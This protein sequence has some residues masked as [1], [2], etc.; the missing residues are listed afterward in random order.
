MDG[1]IFGEKRAY[2]NETDFQEDVVGI[3]HALLLAGIF[4]NRL[5]QGRLVG[6]AG[7]E[8]APGGI[9]LPQPVGP[10]GRFTECE[11]PGQG[12]GRRR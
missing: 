12:N 1:A 2:N 3:N 6:D 8:P 9:Y 10:P 7:T 11:I 5:R 4:F